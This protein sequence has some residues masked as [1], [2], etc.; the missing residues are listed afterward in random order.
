[1]A[2][3]ENDD[4]KR[5]VIQG[6]R[7]SETV[8]LDGPPSV[9]GSWRPTPA[10]LCWELDQV[11]SAELY[12]NQV[13]LQLPALMG[14]NV[15][16]VRL[17]VW[18]LEAARAPSP[19]PPEA[20]SLASGASALSPSPHSEATPRHRTEGEESHQSHPQPPAARETGEDGEDGEDGDL[21][22]R[23]KPGNFTSREGSSAQVAPNLFQKQAPGALTPRS[24]GTSDFPVASKRR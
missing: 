20:G 24:W 5:L 14:H 3:D 9:W 10:A 2:N 13:K 18:P 12:L 23:E 4:A 19:P 15:R 6:Q 16:D 17:V 22:R 7:G 11:E 21:P 1:M 8:Y